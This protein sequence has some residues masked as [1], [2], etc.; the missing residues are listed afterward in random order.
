MTVSTSQE[1]EPEGYAEFIADLK[2]RV[3]SAQFRTSRAVNTE[4]LRLYWSVGRD[5]LDR[6]KSAGWGGKVVARIAAT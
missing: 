1:V 6:Q 5:I 4:L 2:E 3:R